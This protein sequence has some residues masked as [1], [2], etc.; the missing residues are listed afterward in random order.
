MLVAL[1]FVFISVAFTE[2]LIQLLHKGITV[3]EGAIRL[4]LD[5]YVPH[6]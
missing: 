4:L 1:A 5:V 6:P 3:V 2:L